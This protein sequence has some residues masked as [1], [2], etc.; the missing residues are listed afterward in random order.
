MNALNRPRVLMFTATLGYGGSESDFLRL[1][2]YLSQKMEVTI[3]LMA[4]DYGSPDYSAAQ[5]QT[6]IPIMVLD[7]E[8]QPARPNALTKALRWWRMIRRL[9]AL[10]RQ[11]DVT[12]SFLSGPNLL[13]ALAGRSA[14]TIVSE[15]GSKLHHVGIS[16]RTKWLWLRLLD[17]L[18]YRLAGS[19][20]PVS[21]GYAEEIAAIA[22]PHLEHKII[23]IEG[24]IDATHLITQTEAPVDADIARFCAVPTAVCCGRLDL[25]KGI[26]LLIHAFARVHRQIPETRL[27]VIGDGPLRRVLLDLCAVEGLSVTTDGN[28]DAA[29]FL[30]GYRLDPVRHFRL[31]RVF[32]FPSLHEGLPNALIEGV[33]SGIPILAADCPWGPRSILSRPDGAS[34]LRTADL[35]VVLANGTLMPLPDTPLGGDEWQKALAAEFRSPAQRRPH[36]DCRASVARFDL[37]ETGKIWIALIEKAMGTRPKEERI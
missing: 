9:R 20:V 28:P 13:N 25:G 17:P 3:A 19:I 37:E 24:G 6:D 34:A 18:T 32:C 11:H 12:I 31:C 33:A 5:S 10:K 1:A 35:P 22:G 21:E 14:A 2:K 36:E 29:V 30:A 8:V 15:R 23:P 4:R 7:E 16:P 26:D 27:L